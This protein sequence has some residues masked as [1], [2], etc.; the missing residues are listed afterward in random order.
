MKKTA[1]L[2]VVSMLIMLLSACGGGNKSENAGEATSS[3]ADGKS[4]TEQKNDPVTITFM[5]YTASGGQEETIKEMIRAF[6]AA[7]PDIKVD[8]QILAY[9]D[10]FTKLNTVI[11]SGNAAPDVFEVG[12]EGFASYAAKDILL[13]LS[14]Y[15]SADTTFN[16]DV[17][18]KLAY[19]AFNYNGKQYGV[20][21]S[22]SNVLLFYNKDLFDA[23]NV[24]YPQPDWTWKD[25]LAAAQKLTDPAHGIWG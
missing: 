4:Q 9:A 5:N 3:P 8:L 10:Y 19:S 21:E 13:D 12:Y 1:L 23:K 22:F 18:K 25:E 14:P 7:N 11:G 15:I 16:S 2:L 24:E 6:E 17:F 20:P